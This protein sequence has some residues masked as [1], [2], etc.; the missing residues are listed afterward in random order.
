[1]CIYRSI[2]YQLLLFAGRMLKF[3][4]LELNSN[5][6]SGDFRLVKILFLMRSLVGGGLFVR[7]FV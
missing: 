7:Y 2:L 5:K 6:S 1:M 4:P 3:Q